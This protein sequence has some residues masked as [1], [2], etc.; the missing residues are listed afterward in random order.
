MPVTPKK[1]EVVWKPLPGAQTLAVLSPAQVT[2]YHGTRGG[3]KT[4]TQL[5]RFH[6]NVGKGYG[7][8]WRGLI[9]DL[10]FDHLSGLVTESKK[11]FPRFEMGAKFHESMAVYKWAWPTGEELLFRHVKKIGDYDGFHGHEYT[12][13]GWNELTKHAGPELYDKFKS[14]NRCSFDPEIDTPKIQKEN[15]DVVY[16]TPNGK[17]LQRP[18]LEE[19]NTCNPSGPGHNWVKKRFI[20]VAP[21]NTI[22]KREVEVFNPQTQ[23]RETLLKTQVAI[24]GSYMDNKFLTPEYVA[25]LENISDPH[26]RAAWLLGSWD[27]TAGGAIDDL[28][29]ARIHIVPRFIIPSSWRLDRSYDD[30][31]SHPFSVGWWAESD[32]TEA[33]ISENGEESIFCPQKGS[34]IQFGEWYGAAKNGRGEYLQNKGL[35]MS[36]TDVAR[37]IVEREKSFRDNG[38][39]EGRIF[40]GPADNRIR[41]VIDSSIETTEKIMATEGVKWKESDKSP[42]SRMIGLRVLR[43]RLEASLRFEGPGIYFMRNCQATIEFLPPIPRD[44]A[45]PD[46]VATLSQDHVYDMV[47]YRVL[48]GKAQ[49]IANAPKIMFPT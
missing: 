37:G 11:W 49:T 23:K 13:L 22:H 2:L 3:G 21:A 48:A 39:A 16:D 15:G 29:N 47:R 40:P 27:V 9:L 34:I 7:Q 12:F 25:D 24:F 46:D 32:G 19:F 45:K 18:M 38:W 42:G 36:A 8:F 43:E 35:R 28:W 20:D 26:I 17:P 10:E 30:G 1:Y 41:Q 14:V 5:M 44:E 4:L 6:R 31:S 33:I